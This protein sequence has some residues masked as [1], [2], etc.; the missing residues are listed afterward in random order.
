M[1]TNVPL[2]DVVPPDQYE[3]DD[4]WMVSLLVRPPVVNT[5]AVTVAA[6]EGATTPDAFTVTVPSCADFDGVPVLAVP[7]FA[8]GGALMDKAACAV[9]GTPKAVSATRA[10]T[11]FRRN[12]RWRRTPPDCQFVDYAIEWVIV[13]E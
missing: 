11:A 9:A 8:F 3:I 4:V 7:R 5:V 13:P 2:V 6:N 10:L 1:E 12:L